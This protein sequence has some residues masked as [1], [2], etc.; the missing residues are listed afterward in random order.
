MNG[1]SNP[2]FPIGIPSNLSG[3]IFTQ[4]QA[5]SAA[6]HM[7]PWQTKNALPS[8]VSVYTN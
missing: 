8:A 5:F 7:L 6:S 4:M 1:V 3:G 2:L